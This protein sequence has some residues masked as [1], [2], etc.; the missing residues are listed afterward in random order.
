MPQT[1]EMKKPR[2]GEEEEDSDDP[3]PSRAAGRRGL[4]EP[5]LAGIGH[6][7]VRMILK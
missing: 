2:G 7:L 3:L 5:R 1:G 4:T 6:L